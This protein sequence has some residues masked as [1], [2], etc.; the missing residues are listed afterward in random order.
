MIDIKDPQIEEKIEALVDLSALHE[1]FMAAR[2]DMDVAG[3]ET[4]MVRDALDESEQAYREAK[5]ACAKLEAV[6]VATHPDVY[7]KTV[8]EEKWIYHRFRHRFGARDE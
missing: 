8:P 2:A 1:L 6:Y 4:R 7:E 3:A 5:Q